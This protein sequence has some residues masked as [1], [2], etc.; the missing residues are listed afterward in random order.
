[1]KFYFNLLLFVSINVCGS[2]YFFKLKGGFF[3]K[4]NFGKMFENKELFQT[5]KKTGL[6]KENKIINLIKNVKLIP[7]FQ[8]F[9]QKIFNPNYQFKT[10]IINEAKKQQ[11]NFKEYAIKIRKRFKFFIR[12]SKYYPPIKSLMNKIIKNNKNIDDELI[13]LF[14][15]NLSNKEDI[16]S[17]LI[18]SILIEEN[19]DLKYKKLIQKGIILSFVIME[20]F[21]L[22]S[23]YEPD[24]E[25]EEINKEIEESNKKIEE[26][27]EQNEIRLKLLSL[28]LQTL[29]RYYNLK[30]KEISAINTFSH[31][32]GHAIES[33]FYNNINESFN[34]SQ[35]FFNEEQEKI[36][37]NKQKIEDAE[38][39]IDKYKREIEEIYDLSLDDFSDYTNLFFY[40]VIISIYPLIINF[41]E[42]NINRYN[43]INAQNRRIN[44]EISLRYF[45][46]REKYNS[47]NTFI[48]KITNP[49]DIIKISLAGAAVEKII[50]IESSGKIIQAMNSDIKKTISGVKDFFIKKIGTTEKTFFDILKQEKKDEFVKNMNE[51]QKKLNIIKK[52]EFLNLLKE[53]VIA[54]IIADS[55]LNKFEKEKEKIAEYIG[56]FI[57]I[58]MQK[59]IEKFKQF[60]IPIKE[61]AVKHG[62]AANGGDVYFNGVEMTREF[63]ESCQKNNIKIEVPFY[64]RES[65]N[66]IDAMNRNL[67]ES[68]LENKEFIESMEK[69]ISLSPVLNSL[70]Q[71]YLKMTGKHIEKLNKREFSYNNF[72]SYQNGF[73]YLINNGQNAFSINAFQKNMY[74]VYPDL[75]QRLFDQLKQNNPAIKI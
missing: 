45:F 52:D 14:G 54:K 7:K 8:I 17:K 35:K 56:N 71:K 24:K 38:K 67:I 75:K 39:K 4:I 66:F 13:L 33:I 53:D 29:S 46:K 26:F 65:F 36:K 70:Q 55:D 16:K 19:Y 11:I 43:I 59:E 60:E 41:E 20:L 51:A 40:N 5:N 44:A 72:I 3:G 23:S 28:F 22:K 57:A 42:K 68:N 69:S 50:A 48:I 64:L 10:R 25:I 73:N 27:N 18:K 37:E 49:I 12:K 30:Y 21:L 61:L 74:K 62:P 6:F 31:E 34:K 2:N 1:M 32:L 9:N 63:L 47:G 58:E 15:E